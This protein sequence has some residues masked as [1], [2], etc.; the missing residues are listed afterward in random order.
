MEDARQWIGL[1]QYNLSTH[2][3]ISLLSNHC[4]IYMNAEQNVNSE[5]NVSKEGVEVGRE[6]VLEI[7]TE[8][9][10]SMYVYYM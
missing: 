9:L 7:S 8:T 10:F 2:Y 4:I 5:R 6:G 1:L 3:T